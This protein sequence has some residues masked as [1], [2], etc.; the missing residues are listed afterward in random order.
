VKEVCERHFKGIEDTRCQCDIDYKLADV[1]IVVMCAI[2]CGL[3][4]LDEIITYGKEKLEFFTEHFGITKIPSE[5]TLSRIMNM[6]NGDVMAGCVIGIIREMIGLSGDIIAIDGKTICS[7]AKKNPA[8]EKLHIVTAYLTGNGVTLGQLAVNEKTNEIPVLR[9]LLAMIDISGKIITADAM[10][11]QKETAK[12][13]IE[14]GGDYVLGLKANQECLY[15]EIS[16]YI[17]DCVS[18]KTIKVETAQTTEKNKDRLEQRICCKA[19]D[20][21]WLESKGEWSGLK[22]AFAIHRKTTTK[23]GQSEE[24]SYYITSL[25]LP[26][27]N[28]MGIVR[29]H[30]KIE[31]MHWFLDVVFSEDDCR[32]LNSNGQKTMNIFRKFAFAMHKMHIS[33]LKQKTKPSLK[34]NMLKALISDDYLLNVIGTDL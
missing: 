11:C 30:W 3:E 13:I 10:H 25:D 33:G 14:R 24:T 21:D 5:S 6:V 23:I 32:I 1:L 27:Q 29:E 15:E 8:R 26:A 19:P 17:D 2:L 20:L 31:S 22:T 7:T 16:A 12:E 9:E 28:L 34:K 4:E 18:D